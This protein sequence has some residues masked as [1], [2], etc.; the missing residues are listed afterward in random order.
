MA[1]QFMCTLHY[2][3]DNSLSETDEPEDWH[4]ADEHCT[5]TLDLLSKD[6]HGNP[7]LLKP[8]LT[9]HGIALGRIANRDPDASK[10]DYSSR[11]RGRF[12]QVIGLVDDG[13]APPYTAITAIRI[14]DEVTGASKRDGLISFAAASCDRSGWRDG[15]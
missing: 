15:E 3:L 10:A 9:G 14:S 4:A 6:E 13:K 2:A 7:G 11:A 8:V 12:E 5:K 1:S